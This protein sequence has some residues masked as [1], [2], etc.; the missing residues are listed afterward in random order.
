MVLHDFSS[1]S[2]PLF[3]LRCATHWLRLRNA[4]QR[5][6][7]ACKVLASGEG[8]RYKKEGAVKQLKDKQRLTRQQEIL[9]TGADEAIRKGRL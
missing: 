8:T 9:L 6:F 3:K 2:L 7:P 4:S 1:G 5:G